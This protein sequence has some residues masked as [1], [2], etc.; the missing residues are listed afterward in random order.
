MASPLS[1]LR[2]LQP[3]SPDH[4][5]GDTLAFA[6]TSQNQTQNQIATL[7]DCLPDS[8]RPALYDADPARPPLDHASLRS[9][10]QHFALPSSFSS[11]SS[12]SRLD[13]N[14]KRNRLGPNTRVLLLLPTGPLNALALLAISAYHTCAPVNAACTPA[15]LRED[16]VR[17]GARVLVTTLE[18]AR[19]LEVGRLEGVEV[20][21]VKGR[22]GGMA[23]LFDMCLYDGE[24]GEAKAPDASPPTTQLHSL[25][26][27]SLILH[28]SG[29]SGKKKVVP[30]SLL[31]LIV[32]TCAVVESWDLRE[33]DVN[34]NMMPLFHVGGIVRNLLAV[35]SD[36]IPS[37]TSS[38]SSNPTPTWQH[39]IHIMLQF[40]STSARPAFRRHPSDFDPTLHYILACPFPSL[41]FLSVY[42]RAGTCELV[43]LPA[44]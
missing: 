6:L 40:T 21:V 18:D 19:R 31:S 5:L 11:S 23:G 7:L 25:T 15:E 24:D 28:T 38:F 41:P 13:A 37:S 43:D 26:D 39:L 33:E 32:G 8:P 16:A 20:V 22:E 42:F 34:L 1:F 3:S 29:T 27:Q 44:D 2:G 35:S 10:V 4:S 9:F 36:F 14:P 30:Y 17:L 12:R